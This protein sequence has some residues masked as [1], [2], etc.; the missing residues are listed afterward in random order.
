MNRTKVKEIY[1]KNYCVFC[2]EEATE[3]QDVWD[4]YYLYS[5][6]DSKDY[7]VIIEK[8]VRLQKDIHNLE[9]QCALEHNIEK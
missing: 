7:H 1:N 2:N 6:L 8:Q 9:L 3:V 4:E 5:C